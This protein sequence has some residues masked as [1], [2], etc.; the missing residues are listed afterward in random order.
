MTRTVLALGGGG[1]SILDGRRHELQGKA[2]AADRGG[3]RGVYLNEMKCYG[4]Y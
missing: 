3:E 4:I 2:W 1:V